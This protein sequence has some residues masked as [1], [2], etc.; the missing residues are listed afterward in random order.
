[1]V[2]L[3]A[4]AAGA[5]A[6]GAPGAAAGG[7]AAAGGFAATGR[8]GVAAAGAAGF[9]A[10]AAGALGFDG[11]AVRRRGRWSSRQDF[12]PVP[13]RQHPQRGRKPGRRGQKGRACWRAARWC[14]GSRR[15]ASR[16]PTTASRCGRSG[17]A[18]RCVRC[19]GRRSGSG[20]RGSHD[21]GGLGHRWRWRR[22]GQHLVHDRVFECQLVFM[23]SAGFLRRG[24]Q[25]RR[26]QG[27]HLCG[28]QHQRCRIQEGDTGLLSALYRWRAR[29]G[30]RRGGL[31][32]GCGGIQ[33]RFDRQVGQRLQ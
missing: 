7:A 3:A 26:R 30:R 31:G 11:A 6:A 32:A 25:Y 1:M 16:R 10:A 2:V 19:P 21:R 24:G 13:V 12:V 27:R 18:P 17:H 20:R 4:V 5:A 14:A 9:G 29:G 28:V 33:G 15:R 8:F 22:R 23:L